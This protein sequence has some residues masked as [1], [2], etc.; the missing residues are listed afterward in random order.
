MSVLKREAKSEN[1]QRR[2]IKNM[3]RFN[4]ELNRYV[5]DEP[6]MEVKN[7]EG[8]D[9]RPDGTAMQVGEWSPDGSHPGT[10]Y[11]HPSFRKY[12]Q[13]VRAAFF[14]SVPKITD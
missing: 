2:F 1:W 13:E 5:D 14:N 7:V 11:S 3:G 10:N 8:F 12:L 4:D 6:R 9:C